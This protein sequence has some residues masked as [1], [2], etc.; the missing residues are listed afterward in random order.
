MLRTKR[1]ATVLMAEATGVD[2]AGRLVQTAAG[3]ISYDYLVTA[4]GSTHSYFGQDEWAEFAPGLKRIEDATRIRRRILLA[5]EQAEFADT[6]AE[7]QRL[8]TFVI[9]G[10]GATGVEMAGPIAEVARQ[11]LAN[12]FRRIDP[13]SSRIILLEAGPHLLPNLTED[14]SRYA[15][16]A[17]TR[18]G[19]DVRTS[20]RV[21]DC[22]RRGV[23]LDHD[24]IDAG[25]VIW[26]AG[27]VASPAAIWLDGERDHAGRVRVLPDLSV[28][29]HPEV[30]VIGD[31]AA[32][33]DQKGQAVPGVAPAAK[34]MG[35]Y[36][37]RLIA[38]RLARAART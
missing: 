23:A 2:L 8:L 37:G 11:T 21:T 38:P 15:E 31:A 13:R 4:T 24:R 12:D 22:D 19:V 1:N 16:R 9:V 33:Y 26:A 20:T 18:M 14:L 17:L 29:Q 36:V 32:G 28:R 5:F 10:G 30:F 7:R 35:G 34:Q 6:E 3:P 25:A 27:V